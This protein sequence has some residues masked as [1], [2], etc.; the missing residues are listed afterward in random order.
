MLIAAR[1][2]EVEE[3][4]ERRTIRDG[5]AYGRAAPIDLNTLPDSA[6]FHEYQQHRSNGG[7]PPPD[8]RQPSVPAFMRRRPPPDDI[9]L[10]EPEERK[11]HFSDAEPDTPKSD[12]PAPE[13]DQDEPLVDA[14]LPDLLVLKPDLPLVSQQLRDRLAQHPMAVRTRRPRPP[15]VLPG[16]QK[17]GPRRFTRSAS[18]ASFTPPMKCASV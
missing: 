7:A 13:G 14:A 15:D 9:S 11:E 12:Q 1:P 6:Q 16:R 10:P 17:T 2:P 3:E 8:P 18:K 5:L 4:K